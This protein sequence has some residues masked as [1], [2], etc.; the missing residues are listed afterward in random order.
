MRTTFVLDKIE[1]KESQV[2]TM[3]IAQAHCRRYS[4]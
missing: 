2:T 4:I 1:A 3:H